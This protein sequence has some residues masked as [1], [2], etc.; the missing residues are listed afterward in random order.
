MTRLQRAGAFYAA[1]TEAVFAELAH[2]ADRCLEANGIPPERRRF[3]RSADMRYEKQG[4]ELT[5]PCGGP[6]TES[7]LAALVA[8]F[9]ALHERLYTFSDPAAPV[10]IV[11]QRVEAA[12]LT[13]KFALPELPA[14]PS[15]RPEPAG[16][17]LACLDGDTLRATPTYRRESLLAG[18]TVEGPAIVDQLD[19]TTVLLPGQTART[20]RYG[21][22]VIS[23]GSP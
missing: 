23:E 13:D 1:A 9:H 3:H 14:A 10:E 19:S 22:L 16:E 11:N 8:D 6:V 17:R 5:V 7:T 2:E 15:P 21:N 12:G 18:H 20:D 4:V